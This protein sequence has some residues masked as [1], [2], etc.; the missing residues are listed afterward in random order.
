ME[1]EL[2]GG[3][4]VGAVL[5]D[6]TVR[7]PAGP[8]T[9][10]VHALLHHLERRGFTGAPRAL[11]LDE[12]GR[13]VLSYLP[14]I[15][16][17]DT[18]P[19]PA[20]VYSDAALEQVGRWLRGYHD[21]VSDFVPPPDATWRLTSRPW[22]PG[23]VVGHNDAAPYNAVWN[24]QLDDGGQLVGF[25]DWDFAAPC[26]RLW[27]L[28]FVAFAWVP[29]HAR[30]VVVA[31]G[32]TDFEDRPRRLRL[33]LEAYGWT[34]TLNEVLDAVK[35]RVRA[36]ID[37]LRAMA[38]HDPLFRRLLDNGVGDTLTQALSELAA[39]RASFAS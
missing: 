6:G 3:N 14:G 11:G 24:P 21:M 13:E 39:D 15:T 20:W 35:A 34:G 26:P 38:D 9:P 19:W 1:E 7:R 36:H 25:I 28:A 32:F 17:A 37:G 22:Q 5:L 27:D 30:E 12:Q 33:L 29:L 2:A 18:R 10:A 8:W 31:E 16:V 4:A 23:D